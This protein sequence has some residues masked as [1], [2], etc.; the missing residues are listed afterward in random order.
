MDQPPSNLRSPLRAL[1]LVSLFC[2][3]FCLDSE[4]LETWAKRV[5]IES[6]IVRRLMAAG[7]TTVNLRQRATS[8]NDL[9]Q[10]LTT[11][12]GALTALAAAD[13]CDCFFGAFLFCVSVPLLTLTCRI[14]SWWRQWR[15]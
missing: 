13:V 15:R 8:R 11:G 4:D 12:A 1:S 5:G 2:S 7:W 10:L 3:L 9:Y 6:G 14:S